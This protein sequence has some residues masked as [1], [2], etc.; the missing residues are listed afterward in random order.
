MRCIISIIFVFYSFSSIAQVDEWGT[1]FELSG[2]KETPRYR[3]TMDYCKRLELNSKWVHMT[4]FGKSAMGRDLPLLIIDKQGLSDPMSLHASGKL[5]LLIQACI[6]PG[7]SEGKD[8]GLMLIRD[9]VINKKFPS[10]LD[11]VS[12]LF[13]PIFNVDG[14]ERFGPYNRVNQNGPKEMGW[15]VTAN[16][17]NLNRDYLKAD[18]P[19]MQAW[20]KMFNTWMPDFFIDTHTTDGADY[21]YVLTYQMELY[22]DMDPAL[23]DWSKN[24][25]LKAWSAQLEK[26][27]FP[28]FPYIVFRDWHNPESGIE[29]SVGAPMLSQVYTSLRNRPG[30]LIETHMLKPY[31]QRV[32]ATY[33]ALKTSI[34]ILGLESVNLKNLIRQADETTAGQEFRKTGFPLRFETLNDSTMVNFLGIGYQKVK[35]KI[36]GDDYYQYDKKNTTFRIPYFDKTKPILFTRLPEAY[37]IPAEWKTVIDRL[38]LHGITVRRL[39]RDTTLTITTWKCSNPRWQTNPFEG[40]HPLTGFEINEISISRDF[41]AGSAIVDM[42]QPE[43][44]IIAHLLEPKGNGS[45][46]YW[47]FFDAIFEQKEYAEHY[48]MEVMAAKMMTED[49]SLKVEF[50]KKKAEDTAFAKNADAIL[51]WFYNKSPYRDPARDIYPVGKIFDRK[52]VDRLKIQ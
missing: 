46:L 15:R 22:G 41:S 26:T 21:Q 34:G 10:L 52:V 23:T 43:A 48:I 1:Y 11:H 38:E 8:A 9:L 17:L 45:F 5:V 40:R 24:T 44:K 35:S 18:A 42:A 36:T 20:L 3:E 2:K 31:E 51:N 14:H 50:E 29:I 33:E 37:I 6:H 4:F 47:G 19:E 13:I 16:N 7:E 30:L 28:V 27:G 39:A 49:P 25:F 12:I 32:S